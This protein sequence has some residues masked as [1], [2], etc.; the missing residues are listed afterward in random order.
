MYKKRF[1]L[2]M[3]CLL[4]FAMS[5]PQAEAYQVGNIVNKAVYTDIVA[6]INDYN[7]AS[8]NIDGYTAVVAEDLR[9]YG[10]DV[11]WMQDE[12]ALYIRR[13]RSN[14]VV[15]TYIAPTIPSKQIGAKAFDVLYT[16]IKTYINGQE[17]ASYNIDGKTIIS[18]NDLA[19]FGTISYN[20]ATRRLDLDI[21]DG[22]NYKISMPEAFGGISAFT[23]SGLYFK[24]NSADGLQIR[25]TAT[26]H[27]NKT[28]KYYT[29]HYYMINSVGDP[30]YDRY[31]NCTF[32]IKTIGPVEAEG[33]IIDYTDK[34][35][36]E[37]YDAPCRIIGLMTIDLEYMDGT[38]ETIYYNQYGKQ[39]FGKYVL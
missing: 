6:S 3:V 5:L 39:E 24:M 11:Q 9:N 12:R 26:N 33:L 25:W 20:D 38:T 23:P 29:T 18:F 4:I 28:I 35:K 22:L 19:A 27:T 2:F 8:H 30:A 16:D 1:L 31:G 17:V 14:T 37:V 32:T 21:A 15:S 13:S 7:I 34:Y 36:A 10:F